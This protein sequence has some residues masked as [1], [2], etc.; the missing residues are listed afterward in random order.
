MCTRRV[1]EVAYRCAT[2]AQFE[3]FVDQRIG[4]TLGSGPSL[5]FYSREVRKSFLGNRASGTGR[6]RNRSRPESIREG[7]GYY[8]LALNRT[9]LSS[10][11]AY[12]RATFY[13]PEAPRR[14][15]PRR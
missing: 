1:I 7:Q 11:S 12:R 3:K 6:S 14:L 15:P 10:T 2:S 9:P 8:A 5:C 13:R 4:R